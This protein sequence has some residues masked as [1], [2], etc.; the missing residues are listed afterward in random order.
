MED[1]VIVPLHPQGE[2]PPLLKQVLNHLI[3]EEVEHLFLHHELPPPLQKELN[4]HP[5]HSVPALSAKS[6]AIMAY[7]YATQKGLGALYVPEEELYSLVDVVKACHD[8][9]VP[10]FLITEGNDEEV[11]QLLAPFTCEQALLDQT[12]DATQK[13]PSLKTSAKISGRPVLLQISEKFSGTGSPST[14]SEDLQSDKTALKEALEETEKLLDQAERPL[15]VLGKEIMSFDLGHAVLTFLERKGLPYVTTPLA[16]TVI[17]ERHPLFVGVLGETL[18]P[19][20]QKRDLLLS[21][22]LLQKDLLEAKPNHSLF[23]SR[24]EQKIDH[25][26]YKKILLTDFVKGLVEMRNTPPREVHFPEKHR[27][28]LEFTIEKN[29]RSDSMLIDESHQLLQLP[30][31]KRQYLTSYSLP[32]GFALPL[33]MGVSLAAPEKRLLL[34]TT[35]EK[36][37]PSLGEVTHLESLEQDPILLIEGEGPLPLQNLAEIDS[38]KS[39]EEHLKDAL[40]QRGR[41]HAI[42]FPKF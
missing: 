6:A 4:K 5:I 20:I 39:L 13:I 32:E 8:E 35:E 40:S 25:H 16:K 26:L 9:A 38:E 15:V 27:S 3:Q 2:S 30:L 1:S 37:L 23:F 29:L 21:L 14:S 33:S 17:D 11:S 18:L 10:L 12:S 41:E 31:H 24:F 42:K 28:S 19:W 22:G 36:F 34:M 7:G